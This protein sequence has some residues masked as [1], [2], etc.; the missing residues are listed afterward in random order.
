MKKKYDKYDLIF[1]CSCTC[2]ITFI[3][4]VLLH[5]WSMTYPSLTEKQYLEDIVKAKERVKMVEVIA[6]LEGKRNYPFKSQ[7]LQHLEHLYIQYRI[8]LFNLD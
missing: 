3:I 7:E 6:E 1:G 2:F 4:C 8:N 5:S